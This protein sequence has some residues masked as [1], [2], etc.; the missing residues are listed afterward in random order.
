VTAREV[1][2]EVLRAGGR[3][4]PDPAR[5]RVVVPPR[6]RPLVFEHREALRALVLA[7][8]MPVNVAPPASCRALTGQYSHPWPDTLAGLGPRRVGPFSPCSVCEAWS[9]VRFGDRVL[10]LACAA[11]YSEPVG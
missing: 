11:R 2:A 8:A 7:D 1:L 4:I 9:W 6:L 10:C 5:P 3:V